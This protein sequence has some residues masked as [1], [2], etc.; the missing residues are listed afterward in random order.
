MA[1]PLNARSTYF[2]PLASRNPAEGTIVRWP[3]VCVPAFVFIR[4]KTDRSIHL[5]PQMRI[6][7]QNLHFHFDRRF[8]AIGFGRNFR[9]HTVPV[10]IRKCV[11]GHDGFLMRGELREIV[12][13]NIESAW[14]SFK[15]A[16]ETTEPWGPPC[17]A[18]KLAVISS[19]FSAVRSRIVPL[20]GARIAVAS[21]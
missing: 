4:N 13:R 9:N 8:L 2:F 10:K 5:R 1:L 3:R 21:S 6:R 16:R 17:R 19:P 15:S 11:H 14:I 12:L 18:G 7:I 20:T